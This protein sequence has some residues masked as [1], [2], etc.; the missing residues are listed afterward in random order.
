MNSYPI[1]FNPILKE[2]V[3]G[4]NRL[5]NI[6]NKQTT[7]NNVGESWEISG[8]SGNISTVSNGHYKG[9]SLTALLKKHKENFLG[10]KNYMTYG[11]NFPLLIKFLD[12]E[13]NLSVQ[14]HPDDAMAKH[15]NSF[16]KTEMW[17]I[18]DNEKDAEII[19]G[20]KNKKED[21]SVLD[22]ITKDNVYD[23]FNT[24]K[25]AQG[26]HYF[27]PAGKVHAIGAG[28]LAAE[29]QQTSDITFRVYDWDRIDEQGNTRE[30]HKKEAI[31]A[32]KVFKD[33]LVKR[34]TLNTSEKTLVACPYFKTNKL[35]VMNTM[36]KDYSKLD[37]F[38]VIMCVE[39][40]GSI[41]VD[42]HSET[43][44][45]GETILIPA[46]SKEVLFSCENASFLEVY[47]AN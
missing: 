15:Y 34:S 30:L 4:G 5:K 36:H 10:K 18:I 33:T 26:D 14:V 38:V 8:V 43:I 13:T 42:N 29:I 12:A 25:V 6:L 27:I 37:S 39:G 21:V 11:N 40:Q 20:L 3:W 2:K 22:A 45:K 23:I 41:A 24:V 46:C 32:T 17:Y 35:E 1:K 16:G 31:A 19:M 28:V 44:T 47:S 9:D 7:K